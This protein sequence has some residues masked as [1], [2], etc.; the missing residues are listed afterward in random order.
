MKYFV[1]VA[2]IYPITSCTF[3]VGDCKNLSLEARIN[4][5]IEFQKDLKVIALDTV[6]SFE[7]SELLILAPYS[8]LDFLEEEYDLKLDCVGGA[9]ESYDNIITICFL[10]NK[11]SVSYIELK[12]KFELKNQEKIIYKKENSILEIQM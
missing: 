2:L 10:K 11:E 3:T 7:W 8:Q 6:K 5:I 9:I 1:I 12:R 4:D